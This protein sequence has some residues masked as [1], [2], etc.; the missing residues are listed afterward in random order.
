MAFVPVTFFKNAQRAQRSSCKIMVSMKSS[1]SFYEDDSK[2]GLELLRDDVLS[3]L[4]SRVGVGPQDA[5]LMTDAEPQP[6]E[7]GYRPPARAQVRVSDLGL[8][9]FRD[10]PNYVGKAG[11]LQDLDA[12]AEMAMNRAQS[13]EDARVREIQQRLGRDVAE[14]REEGKKAG[15]P[16]YLQPLEED[17]PNSNWVNVVNGKRLY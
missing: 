7:P 6:G 15:L 13:A 10:A 3:R 9:A 1:E 8:S 2:R 17:F 5:S 16:S 11:G 12:Q 4:P 14:A